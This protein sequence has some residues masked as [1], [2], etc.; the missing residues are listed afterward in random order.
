MKWKDSDLDYTKSCIFI[1]ETGFNINMRNRWARSAV[2]TTVPV[3]IEKTRSPFRIT[4][5]AIH[6]S[7]VIHVAMKK[8]PLKKHKG[9]KTQ[10]TKTAKPK[11]RKL[12]R[13][14][15][16]KAGDIIIYELTIEYVNV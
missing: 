5:G 1:D 7:N 3:E 14:P 4:I 15:D 13:G 8:P 10:T 9:S 6:C 11:T 2:R 16:Q 12:G